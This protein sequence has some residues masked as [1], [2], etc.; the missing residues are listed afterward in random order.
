MNQRQGKIVSLVVAVIVMVVLITEE[1]TEEEQMTEAPKD[2]SDWEMQPA[3]NTE[4][5]TGEKIK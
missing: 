1:T 2:T 4:P 5:D 3:E